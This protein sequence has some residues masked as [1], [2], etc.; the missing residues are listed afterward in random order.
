VLYRDGVEADRRD[1][2][3]FQGSP[4]LNSR[5][6]GRWSVRVEMAMGSRYTTGSRPRWLI[7]GKAGAIRDS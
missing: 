2:P 1:N 4:E 7:P 6:P 3:V 5:T